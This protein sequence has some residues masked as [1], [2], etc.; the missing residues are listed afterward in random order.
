MREMY[1]LSST[2]LPLS[3]KFQ[4]FEQPLLRSP[5]PYSIQIWLETC[6]TK[7][8]LTLNIITY[9]QMY[10]YIILRNLKWAKSSI[11]YYLPFFCENSHKC[12]GAEK[13]VWWIP[14]HSYFCFD[15]YQD[16]YHSTIFSV[17]PCLIENFWRKC[18]IS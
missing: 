6:S 11:F 1:I 9:T 4:N 8:T 17:V 2:S 14:L 12:L 7:M 5:Y 15:P 10:N 18:Q 13:I 16:F 3:I